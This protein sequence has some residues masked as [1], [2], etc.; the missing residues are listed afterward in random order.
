MISNLQRLVGSITVKE[1]QD[2]IRITGLPANFIE[3]DIRRQWSSSKIAANIFTE[4]GRSH[5]VF[6]KFFAPDVIYTFATLAQESRRNYRILAKVIDLIYEHTWLKSARIAHNPIL[7]FSQL[8]ELTVTM[9]D[10]QMDFL[11]IYNE[12]VPKYNL[13]GYLLAAAPGTGKSLAALAWGLCLHSDMQVLIVPKNSVDEV[14]D[15][16]IRDRF[17]KQQHYWT[18]LSGKPLQ[19]GY[20]YY[21]FHYEQLERALEFF[22]K[23][24]SGFKN[25]TITL[26]ESHNFNDPESLRTQFFVELCRALRCE[27]VLWMSGTPVK[28]IGNEVIPFLRTIDPYF[29]DDAQMRFKNIYGKSASRAVDILSH[30]LGLVTFKVDKKVVVDNKT[31]THR[32]DV[33]IPEGNIYTLDTLRE[34]MRSFIFQRMRYYQENM[35]A[36]I[37]MYQDYLEE[38][39]AKLKTP[40]EKEAFQQYVQYVKMIRKG[41]DPA[42]MKE[43]VMYCNKYELQKIIPSFAKKEDRDNFKNVRSIVKYYQLK[44][45][46]EALGRVLGRKRAQCH[47]DMVP[48]MGLPDMINDS[49]SKTVIFTSYVEVV[50]AID[51]YL[52]KEGFEPSLVYGETTKDLKSIVR[53]FDLNNKINPLVAT[54]DSLSTAVPL[55]MASTAILTNAPF[56]AHEYDQATARVDRM[57]QPHPVTIYNIFLNTGELPNISTR[58]NDIMTWSREQVAQIMGTKVANID[59]AIEAF[60]ELVPGIASIDL[61]SQS[62]LSGW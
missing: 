43:I 44:V 13:N 5:V 58:S 40:A 1:E 19:A 34:E 50:K 16:T 29:D 24:R 54:F 3:F 36:F 55:V 56:R 2:V 20:K 33:S 52:K 31:E 10:H 15:A 45:Q 8:R 28:A 42:T 22:E 17:K 4:I 48:Y 57:G 30:R 25:P 23:Y 53:Q 9:R 11:N 41:Y 6:N 37:A 49:L 26:D 47:V 60:R 27:H 62:N 39:S 21:V 12:N 51:A 38:Y 7:D 61:Q 14:W 32:V 18:S 59:L 35:D 46:G